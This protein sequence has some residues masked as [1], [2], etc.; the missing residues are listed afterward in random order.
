MAFCTS[1]NR[2]CSQCTSKCTS[3]KLAEDAIVRADCTQ[4]LFGADAEMLLLDVPGLLP[5][6]LHLTANVLGQALL[7]RRAKCIIFYVKYL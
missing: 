2:A 4:C 5:S 1:A 7:A 3:E 6:V